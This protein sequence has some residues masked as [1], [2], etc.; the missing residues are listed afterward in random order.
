MTRAFEGKGNKL[1]AGD[2]AQT[3]EDLRAARAA[4]FKASS[5][6]APTP[7]IPVPVVPDTS[8]FQQ[9]VNLVLPSEDQAAFERKAREKHLEEVK[10]EKKM[11][12]EQRRLLQAEI[13]K[14]RALR[15]RGN[16]Y[17]PEDRKYL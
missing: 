9:P 16:G 17:L 15:A 5:N 2:E 7:I 8:V 12:Q 14:D 6:S 13:Q 4:R 11:Q 1:D 3:A 10:R